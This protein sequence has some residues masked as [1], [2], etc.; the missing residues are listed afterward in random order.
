MVNTSL[1]QDQQRV[2]ST[3]NS[4]NNAV[5]I[6]L[7]PSQFSEFLQLASQSTG[8]FV[9]LDVIS[10]SPPTLTPD[11][12]RIWKDRYYFRSWY[13]G[14]TPTLQAIQQKVAAKGYQASINAYDAVQLAKRYIQSNNYTQQTINSLEGYCGATGTLLFAPGT[15]DRQLGDFINL[16]WNGSN[17]QPVA[18]YGYDTALGSYQANLPNATPLA[19]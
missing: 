1:A 8:N 7:F 15:H 4:L 12:Q 19:S 6:G 2:L 18:L 11:Q 13:P 3:L 9:L 16:V 17:W 5:V 14:E 10:E